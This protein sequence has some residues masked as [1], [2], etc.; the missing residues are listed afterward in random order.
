MLAAKI[1]LS[2]VPVFVFLIALVYLD[3]YKLIRFRSVL[4]SIGIGCTAAVAAFAINTFLL[5]I[6][7]FDQVVYTRYA[8]PFIEEGLKASYLV[9]LIRARKVGFMVDAAIYG[10]AIGAGFAFVENVYYLLALTGESNLLV[11]IIRGFGTALMHGGTTAILG[12]ITR[13]MYEVHPHRPLRNV[14]LGLAVAI[15]IHSIFNHFIFSPVISTILIV[16]ALPLIM[17][18]IFNRSEEVTRRWLGTGL[19]SD[20]ELLNLI[21]VGNLTESHIGTY[22]RSLKEHFS[23][24]VV[25]DMLCFIRLHTELAMRAKG[26]L[27]MRKSG[28][29]IPKDPEIK[30][31]FTELTF[32]EKSIGVTGKMAIAPILHT[33]S[34]TLWQLQLI[35]G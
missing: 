15:V 8:A 12:V 34:R 20:L 7:G 10:V 32:L 16:G 19:D 1:V 26:V 4:L 35:E 23:P 2:L 33:G 11:W 17:M 21:A 22:L 6:V 9:Y 27:I 13:T 5:H 14:I 18:L 25:G 30:E 29:D 24:T 3:S 28:F 31:K